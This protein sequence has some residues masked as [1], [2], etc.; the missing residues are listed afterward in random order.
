MPEAISIN[1]KGEDMIFD[2]TLDSGWVE[3]NLLERYNNTTGSPSTTDNNS[4]VVNTSIGADFTI[5]TT[6]SKVIAFHNLGAANNAR[7]VGETLITNAYGGEDPFSGNSS[8]GGDGQYG[9]WGRKMVMEARMYID[10]ATNPTATMI[11]GIG[12]GANNAAIIATSPARA[13]VICYARWDNL[14]WELLVARG[15][16][17]AASKQ[18][19]TGVVAPSLLGNN[20]I[21]MVYDPYAG[22]V[23]AYINGALGATMSDGTKIP[24]PNT[25]TV[26]GMN[27]FAQTGSNAAGKISTA[28]YNPHYFVQLP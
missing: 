22:V 24:L 21:R 14:T 5:D 26:C 3:V 28:F 16:S 4:P 25:G 7:W 18:V 17:T 19:L 1:Y 23:R 11:S 10:V 15:N 13:L 8:E 2:P 12:W 20:R 27:C 9:M 6:F